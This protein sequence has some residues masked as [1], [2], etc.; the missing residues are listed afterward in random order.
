[1]G[2]LLLTS[3]VMQLKQTEGVQLLYLMKAYLQTD[4]V[5]C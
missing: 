2:F 5:S 1:M 4:F 3:T